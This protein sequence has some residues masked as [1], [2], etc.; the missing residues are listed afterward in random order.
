MV[1]TRTVR[2]I[3]TGTM[4]KWYT[5]VVANCQRARV[6]ASTNAPREDGVG[7]HECWRLHVVTS[8]VEVPG[9]SGPWSRAGRRRHMIDAR[10]GPFAL[11]RMHRVWQGR[12]LT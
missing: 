1:A 9:E 5:V 12:Y 7:H 10:S 8:T 6:V 11:S 3:V 2:P 4:R